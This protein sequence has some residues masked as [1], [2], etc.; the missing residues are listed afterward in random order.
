MMNKSATFRLRIPKMA[1]RADTLAAA[2]AAQGFGSRKD[3]QRLV[4]AGKVAVGRALGDAPPIGGPEQ[5]EFPMRWELASDP[6]AP[7]QTAGAWFR[8]GDLE[9]P[10]R[11]RLF[12]AFHKPADSECS[13][14]P[15]HHR[16]VYSYLPEPFLRRGLEAAGRL[17]ADTTGLLFL[18][19]TGE[20]IHHLT[21]PKRHVPKTYQVGL[22]HPVSAEQIAR[23]AAGV[24]LRGEEDVTGPAAVERLSER[25]CRITI[26]EGR[27]HQVKRMFA[28]VGNRV[29]S[30]HRIAIGPIGLEATL[31]E[32]QWRFLADAEVASLGFSG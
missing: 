27:Y 4:R 26:S 7:V 15:T 32:G 13:H 24:E 12:V 5:P 18:S 6:D 16:S 31:P 25:L 21:S 1:K 8:V 22:K 20:F 10:W 19:D 2:M 14:S 11:D 29:E 9:L 3:C 30:I 28:A 17:D 23:L